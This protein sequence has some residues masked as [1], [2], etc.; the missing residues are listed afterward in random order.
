MLKPAAIAATAPH[1]NLVI[2]TLHHATQPA[3]KAGERAVVV[4]EFQ[5]FRVRVIESFKL[6]GC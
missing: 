5:S 4:T 6:K 2:G 3:T 1:T